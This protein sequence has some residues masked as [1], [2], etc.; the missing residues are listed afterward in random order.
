LAA[1]KLLKGGKKAAGKVTDKPKVSFAVGDT[2]WRV[3]ISLAQ[4]ADYFYN[5]ADAGI[6]ARLKDTGGVIFPYTPQISVNHSARYASQQLTHS[7]YTNYSYEGSE[8]QAITIT[9]DFSVQNLDEGQYLMACIYFFRAATKMWFG[10]GSR[11]GN[12]PP[13]VFLTGYGSHYF[14]NVPCVVTNFQHT[15]PQD[16]DYIDIPMGGANVK[17]GDTKSFQG[18]FTRVPT[19]SQVTV[20]LQPIYTRRNLYDKFNLDDFAAGKLIKGNGG[21]M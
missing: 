5:A 11:V 7:N 1:A 21:Y 4:S 18:V 9:G 3:R 20:T 12:P 13:M 15:L 19:N 10:Q 2:D 8:V 17:N 6:M 14:P 16:V